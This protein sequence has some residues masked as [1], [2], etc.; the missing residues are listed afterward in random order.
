MPSSCSHRRAL[1]ER[2]SESARSRHHLLT[3]KRRRDRNP[4]WLSPSR[5]SRS[6]ASLRIGLSLEDDLGP[7]R[8][9]R[10]VGVVVAATLMSPTSPQRTGGHGV[11]G[12]A[13]PVVTACSRDG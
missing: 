3:A 7:S 1:G 12:R 6:N 9:D 8:N 4:P 5:S 13:C 11:L 2:P 10:E